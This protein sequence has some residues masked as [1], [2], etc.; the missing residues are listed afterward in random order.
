MNLI[1]FFKNS[2]ATTDQ[3][4]FPVLY[5]DCPCIKQE[6]TQPKTG[7]YTESTIYIKLT[8]YYVFA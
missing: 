8:F 3:G 2:A 1:T 5:R 6:S 4:P 7:I